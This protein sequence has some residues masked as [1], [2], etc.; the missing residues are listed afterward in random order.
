MP[1]RYGDTKFGHESWVDKVEGAADR[2][3]QMFCNERLWEAVALVEIGLVTMTVLALG[4]GWA[5]SALF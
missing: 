2:C 1:L 4:V 3:V 5:V